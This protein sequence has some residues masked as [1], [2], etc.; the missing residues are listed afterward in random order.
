MVM[1]VKHIATGNG[2]WVSIVNAETKE[3][4]KQW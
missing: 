1:L 4:A 2:T 3:Q